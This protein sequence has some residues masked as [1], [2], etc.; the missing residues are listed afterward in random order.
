M[1][2]MQVWTLSWEDLLD[3]EMTTHSSIPAWEIP[4]TEKPGGL[5]SIRLQ[6]IGYQFESKQ[7][8]KR[9]KK[10]DV[11]HRREGEVAFPVLSNHVIFSEAL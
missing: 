10:K 11:F 8:Y 3:E 7:N 9:R 4:W 1:Q 2:E 5:Q 6:R